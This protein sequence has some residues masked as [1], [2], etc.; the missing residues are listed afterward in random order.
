[1]FLVQVYA[2]IMIMFLYI[3]C[4]LSP[5][6]VSMVIKRQDHVVFFYWVKFP[7][8]LNLGEIVTLNLN[9]LCLLNC[10]SLLTQYCGLWFVLLKVTEIVTVADVLLNVKGT[11]CYFYVWYSSYSF[12]IILKAE[13]SIS[14]QISERCQQW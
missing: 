7:I 6:N 9:C 12:N 5:K 10:A 11:W 4:L 2:I 14:I 13:L 1:M 3:F 8:M